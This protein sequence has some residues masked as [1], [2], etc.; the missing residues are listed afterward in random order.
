L[1]SHSAFLKYKNEFDAARNAA[2]G[3]LNRQDVHRSLRDLSV[4]VLS[5]LQ[6]NVKLSKALSWAKSKGFTVVPYTLVKGSAVNAS[7]LS[8]ELAARLTKS[9]YAMDGLVLT[10]D[11]MNPLPK[12]GN[13]DWSI[14]FKS[15]QEALATTIREVEWEV[16]A[17]GKLKPVVVYDPIPWDGSTL[18]RASAFNG[19]F[20]MDEGIGIGARITIVRSGDIIP[21]IQTV[22]KK[23]KPSLP[24]K[25][26]FGAYTLVG[27]DFVLDNPLENIDFRVK[28][29]ARFF[30]SV[31]VDFLRESTVR[32]LYSAGFTSVSKITKAQAKDFLAIPGVRLATATKIHT[33]IHTV[34]DAGIPLVTLM[35]A[36][37]VFPSGMGST[38][39]EKIA[40]THDLLGLCALAPQE[41]RDI[42]SA[43]PGF[44]D[45]TAEYFVKGSKKFLKWLALVGITPSQ[46]KKVKVKRASTKLTGIAVTFTGYRS[47]EQEVLVTTNGGTVVSFGSRTQT[48]LVSPEGKASTKEDKAK[49][50]GI[51]VM[52][53]LQF[54]KEHNL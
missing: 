53:W 46:P 18:T 27:A 47:E 36:S 25:D 1:F 8:K 11:E 19:K 45:T 34:I 41:Q 4:V 40:A 9:K 15:N 26:A 30:T 51:P 33:N 14:A 38:R 31:G 17:H 6:P 35:D 13:P 29:I 24:S 20:V 50:K 32:K 44:K 23:S 43:I 12:S 21:Y 42:I 28:K 39:F 2:S 3:I 48:L 49:A 16:S 54:A 22:V 37:G 7:F 5:V 10:I 52:T